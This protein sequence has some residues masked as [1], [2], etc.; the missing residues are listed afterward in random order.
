MM[1]HEPGQVLYDPD[2]DSFLLTP[3]YDSVLVDWAVANPRQPNG[4]YFTVAE[5]RPFTFRW[6]AD[7]ARAADGRFVKSAD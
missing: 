5:C 6:P 2:L 3:D 1:S 7:K 4:P